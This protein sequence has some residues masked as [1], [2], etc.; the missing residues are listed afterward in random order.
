MLPVAICVV[1]TPFWHRVIYILTVLACHKSRNN[2][3]VFATLKNCS[4]CRVKEGPLSAPRILHYEN[5][6]LPP[7]LQISIYK[8]E[9]RYYF[10]I[11]LGFIILHF[12]HLPETGIDLQLT[13]IWLKGVCHEIFDL[14]FIMIRTYL[15]PWQTV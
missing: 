1:E 3:R 10:Y 15:V 4:Y 9:S 2:S 8:L 14:Y 13:G 7:A 11:F 5:C 12:F 6:C